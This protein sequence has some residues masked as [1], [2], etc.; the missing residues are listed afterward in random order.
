MAG[1][2]ATDPVETALIAPS[3]GGPSQSY[4]STRARLIEANTIEPAHYGTVRFALPG[5]GSYLQWKE[6]QPG[7]G[8]VPAGRP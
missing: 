6:Q 5:Y 1:I 3:L 4:T 7:T 8:P 2:S